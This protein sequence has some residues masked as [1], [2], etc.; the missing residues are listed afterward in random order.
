MADPT[1]PF[2]PKIITCKVHLRVD[3]EVQ[4][5]GS[6]TAPYRTIW[7]SVNEVL[8]ELAVDR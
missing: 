1:R 3:E 5:D 2:A 8:D 4:P 7:G 6:S